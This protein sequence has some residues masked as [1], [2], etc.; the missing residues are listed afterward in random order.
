MHFPVDPPVKGF[1]ILFLANAFEYLRQFG[2]GNASIKE[3]GNP[4][5]TSSHLIQRKQKWNGNRKHK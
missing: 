5:D 1:S 4:G 2:D 3:K